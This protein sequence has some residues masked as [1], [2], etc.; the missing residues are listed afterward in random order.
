M[1]NTVIHCKQ[2]KTNNMKKLKSFIRKLKIWIKEAGFTNLVY[3]I[4][5]AYFF[6]SGSAFLAGAALGVFVYVNWNTIIKIYNRD[7]ESE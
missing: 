7:L 4:L 1:T 3:L 6:T 2:K 5:F